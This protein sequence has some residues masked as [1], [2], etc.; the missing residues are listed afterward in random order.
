MILTR[1][2]QSRHGNFAT[3]FGIALIP[4]LLGAGM[5]VD[6]SRY[7]SAKNHLQELADAAAL[8]AAAADLG[9][10][11]EVRKQADR[12]VQAN[13][14]PA[15][16]DSVSI[17]DATLKDHAY[18]VDLS[19]SLKT[20]FMGIANIGHLD[21]DTTAVAVR[22][23]NGSVEVALVLDNTW[24]MSFDD[25]TGVSKIE[26]LKAAAGDLITALHEDEE[27]AIKMAVV[28]YADYVNVGTSHRNESWLNVPEDYTEK[29]E[30]SCWTVTQETVG[31]AR[32]NPVHTCEVVEDGVERSR[33]CGGGCAEPITRKLDPPRQE[34]SEDSET[35]IVWHGCVGSRTLGNLRLS[36]D[37]PSVAYP[38]YVTKIRKCPS[39]I[40]PLTTDEGRLQG[41]ITTMEAKKYGGFIPRTYIPAGLVWGLNVLSPRAPFAEGA[42]YDPDNKKP[43]KV[44]V[45]MTDG[46]NTLRYNET[47][48][49]HPS[50]ETAV[51]KSDTDDDTAAI[52]ENV[53]EQN[54]EIY[55]VAFAV[56]SSDAKSLLEN[57][58]TDTAH[59]FDATNSAALQSA[60]AD[61]AQSLQMVRLAR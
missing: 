28:P 32:E 60:F 61:I 12:Y 55:T 24:S 11:A 15:T 36:D 1:F 10:E 16:I 6:Y 56:D 50:A 14:V 30:G 41:A 45:L 21:V 19:G 59:Y 9:T 43:R 53:K 33:P 44:L 51:E 39:E 52:C 42:S 25:A 49:K 5:A 40:V 18:T 22:G 48:G 4:L 34:C 2:W 13:Y 47:N 7:M 31:C 26:A 57:C 8:A 37:S 29:H 54:I 17:E 23:V 38:G 3:M 46:E 58:A 27:T 20:T 35:P